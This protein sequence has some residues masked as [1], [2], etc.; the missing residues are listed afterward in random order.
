MTLS[1]TIRLAHAAAKILAPMGG[2]V[3]IGKDTRVSGYMLESALEAGFVAA[4]VNVRL[5]GPMPT[6]AIAYLTQ[7][8]KCDFGVVISASHNLYADNG[9]KFF[10]ALGSKLSDEKEAQIEALLAEEALTVHSDHLGRAKRIDDAGILYQQFCKDAVGDDLNLEGLKLVVDCAHGAN[11]KVAPQLLS[12]L[13]ADVI[14]IGCSPN[15]RNINLGC[16]STHPELLSLTVQGVRAHAGIAFDGDGDRLVMVN[17]R[18]EVVDGDQ[19]LYI[20][21]L[22][23]KAAG[24]LTGPVVGTLMT[25]LGLERALVARGIAFERAQVGDR[26]VLERLKATGGIL[27]G[28][29]SGHMLILDKAT[30]GDAL[31]SALEVLKVMV[32]QGQTLADLT[33]GLTKYPQILK[34][35]RTGKRIALD[36][37]LIA[38][39]VEKATQQLAQ[40]G[41]IVLRAS[42]TEPLI[43]VMVEGEDM[44][45]VTAIAE[46][47]AHV[48]AQAAV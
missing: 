24:Q 7:K 32:T 2:M 38:D 11:Y 28:E 34:N 13:G 9:I 48:V 41:R 44:Q 36:Q 31:M 12:Q 6:P 46:H 3:L 15:G 16:G 37:P 27:G 5:V 35:V 4:G 14:P 45:E 23:R 29:T 43:R 47:L 10:D 30:T 26:Y 21:A 19:L 22:G 40:R 39:A 1:F 20:L 8:F 25:N 18:G 33:K 17:H 42:G